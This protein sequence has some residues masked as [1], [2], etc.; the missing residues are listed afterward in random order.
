MTKSLASSIDVEPKGESPKPSDDLFHACKQKSDSLHPPS[1]RQIPE[2]QPS[3]SASPE[4]H[5]RPC[6][7]TSWPTRSVELTLCTQNLAIHLSMLPHECS[8]YEATLQLG[9]AFPSVS[10]C[11]HIDAPYPQSPGRCTGAPQI[12]L[13]AGPPALMPQHAYV[14]HKYSFAGVA[15]LVLSLYTL[16]TCCIRPDHHMVPLCRPVLPLSIGLW[17][18]S[19]PGHLAAEPLVHQ[20]LRG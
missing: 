13:S 6:Q 14:Q 3:P 20:T 7:Q 4:V 19:K 11:L 16:L 2:H 8:Y 9:G 15:S 18:A 5:G 10:R 17:A 1:N 12:G